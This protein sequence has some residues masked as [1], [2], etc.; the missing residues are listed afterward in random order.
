[1]YEYRNWGVNEKQTVD[2]KQIVQCITKGLHKLWPR[3]GLSFSSIFDDLLKSEKLFELC[4]DDD[5]YGRPVKFHMKFKQL[6]I[7]HVIDLL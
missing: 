2:S 1:M 6:V 5:I 3:T 7:G 4:A